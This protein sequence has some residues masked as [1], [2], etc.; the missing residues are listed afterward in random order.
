[1]WPDG[2]KYNEEG[3]L[4]LMLTCWAWKEHRKEHMLDIRPK[5]R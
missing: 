2:M 5:S 4:D 1:M 3:V